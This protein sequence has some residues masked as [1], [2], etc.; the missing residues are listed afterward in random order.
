MAPSEQG[1]ENQRFP[2]AVT[3]FIAARLVVGEAMLP[4][5]YP[6][7]DGLDALQIGFRSDGITG[8]S[9]ISETEGGWQ[10]G[11]HVIAL[12]ELDDPFFVDICDRENGYPVY[13]APHGAGR[14]NATLVA[15]SL[16]RMA[17]ILSILREVKDDHARFSQALDAET[18]M[19]NRF[20]Q[21][22][23][24]ARDEAESENL[25]ETQNDAYDL[26]DYENGDLIVTSLGPQKLQVVQI[27][28]KALGIP[29]KDALALA[30]NG[31]FRAGSGPRIQLRRLRD[32]LEA[33][34]SKVE[35]RPS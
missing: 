9:L 26:K 30:A 12:N 22:V 34:G 1:S 21:E 7:P 14:W 33:C 20:W 3:T 28:S 18:D 25:Q 24:A 16:S 35:F 13:H 2:E 31:E 27:V 23:Q 11:W 5:F 4:A 29:L 8:K 17:E 10:P 6:E 15:P 19:S 32:Q